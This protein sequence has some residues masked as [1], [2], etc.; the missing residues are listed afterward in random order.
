MVFNLADEGDLF[1]IEIIEYTAKVLG[2]ALADF[3]CF[4]SPSAYILFG[5][6]A[7]SGPGFA[8]KVKNYMED[9]LF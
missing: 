7:Q 6:I 9:M 2:E 4:S 1:A 8:N 5:G 3:T